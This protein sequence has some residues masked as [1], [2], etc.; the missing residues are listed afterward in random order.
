MNFKKTHFLKTL[1]AVLL[2]LFS[3]KSAHADGIQI[4]SY[5]MKIILS[6]PNDGYLYI[7]L[8]CGVLKSD[9]TSLCVLLFNSGARISSIAFLDSNVSVNPSFHFKG[10]DTLLIQLP[11][12][13]KYRYSFKLLFNYAFPISM[14]DSS[15]LMLDRG[16]RW[17]P[18]IAD[19]I[20]SVKLNAQVPEGCEVL[21]TGDLINKTSSNGKSTYI[22]ESSMPVFKIPLIVFKAELYNHA[23]IKSG[24]KEIVLYTLAKYDTANTALLN[25]AGNVFKFCTENIGEY[26]YKRLIL[27]EFPEFEGMNIGSGIVE[28]GSSYIDLMKHGFFDGL[29]LV[30]AQQWIGAGVFAKL[31]EPGFWFLSLSLPHYVR[32]MYVRQSAGQ[33]AYNKDIQGQ[34][35]KYEEFAG[36]ENDVPILDV[37]FPN[38]KE[39]GLVLYA[40]GPYALSLLHKQM[41]DERWFDFLKSLYADY[42]GKI[43]TYDAFREM[44]SCFD[45]GTTIPL[46]DKLVKEKGLPE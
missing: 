5:D 24:D 30:I 35:G 17:Y 25:E 36:K 41:G 46:L 32:L 23:S 31:G 12:E 27:L 37:D 6:Q 3:A 11:A 34:L 20:A 1:F 22:W 44:L 19:C 14:T 43:L 26:S 13:A 16:H 33:E 21:S 40:K 9:T 2:I 39:K 10:T 42:R 45:D 7:D 28:I 38:T 18:L 29:R 4:T 8:T 15:I